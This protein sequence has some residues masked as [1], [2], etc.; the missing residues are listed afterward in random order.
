MQ[1]SKVK[2]K[3]EQVIKKKADSQE[4]RKAF[5][6]FNKKKI[7]NMKSKFDSIAQTRKDK[8]ALTKSYSQVKQEI[9]ELNQGGV[10]N[11]VERKKKLEEEKT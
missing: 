10:K 6:E 11:I 5:E 8:E 1:E 4:F 3:K 7:E 9:Q 2:I